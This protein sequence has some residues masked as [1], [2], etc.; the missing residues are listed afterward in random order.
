MRDEGPWCFEGEHTTDR[1][2]VDEKCWNVCDY[3]PWLC[4]N[5]NYRYYDDDD[6]DDDDGDDDDDDDDDD[7]LG[8]DD[9]DDADNDDSTD[10]VAHGASN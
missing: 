10:I 1:A 2:I 6:D 8:D 9:D 5:N 4:E 7:D 3:R